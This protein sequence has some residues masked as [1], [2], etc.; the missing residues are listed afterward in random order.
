[1]NNLKMAVKMMIGFGLVV[2]I[3]CV[4]SYM[5]IRAM[6][7]AENN[8]VAIAETYVPELSMTVKLDRAASNAMAAMLR[9]L[10]TEDPAEG[11]AAQKQLNIIREQVGI[12]E[13][14]VAQ[15]PELEGL[16]VSITKGKPL[17]EE[18]GKLMERTVQLQE[19]LKKRRLLLIDVGTKYMSEVE[20]LLASQ[21]SRLDE[22]IRTGGLT[23]EVERRLRQTRWINSLLDLGAALRLSNFQSQV[24]QDPQIA[25]EGMKSFGPINQTLD[26]LYNS[27]QNADTKAMINNIR[28]AA[29]T[30]SVEFRKLIDEWQSIR[31]V[32][33]ERT[34][35]VNGLLQAAMETSELAMTQV[36]ELSKSSVTAAQAGTSSLVIGVVIGIVVSVALALLLTRMITGPLHKSVEFAEAVAGGDLERDLAIHQKDEIGHLA[37]ALNSMVATLRQRIAEAHAAI[38][39]ATA[40]EQEALAAMGEA[41]EA[42]KQAEQAKR[43]GMLDAA[44]QLENVVASVSTASEQLSAQVEHS[45]AGAQQQ[46]AR[47]S[48]TATAMEEMNATVL[49]VAKNAG[50]TASVSDQAKHKAQDGAD[51]VHQV[52]IGMERIQKSSEELRADMVG[53]SQ[54][55][56]DISAIMDVISDIADQTNLLA[57]NA[58][59]EAARA[60]EAGRG[61][62]VV[63]DEVRKLAENT[64]KATTEV[65]QAIQGIQQDTAKNMANAEASVTAITEVTDMAARSGEA[66]TEIVHLVDQA[67]DQVRAIATASEEQS[68]TSEEIN[69]AIEDITHISAETADAMRM[70]GQAVQDLANQAQIL[71]QL[72]QDM[73]AS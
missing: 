1:V 73:K 10:N 66:L 26:Q 3:M 68:A 54:K 62:A 72:I 14:L 7:E 46:A 53:L 15:Y 8:A 25:E 5:G 28:T 16:R 59:I 35:A 20:T 29:E 48:E 19:N 36:E 47:T 52:I 4:L 71:D 30:Y 9:Y 58:A 69:K 13:R 31:D 63:A 55:A 56:T 41:E 49:E 12:G 44:A 33:V 38:E 51:I 23:S 37:D 50:D 24:F 60:G 70:A 42:R 11:D 6:G 21:E 39:N 40:K 22:V 45:E 43:Q 61:F 34:R 64:M 67:S 65:G 32:G 18:Y 57:L 2:V 17:V 27:V